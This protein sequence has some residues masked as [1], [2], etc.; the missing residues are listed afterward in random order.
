MTIPLSQILLIEDNDLD[1]RFMQS[2][3]STMC[4]GITV[5]RARDGMAGLE[6]V[7]QTSPDVI[8]LDL[9]MPG[10]NGLEVLSRLKG[11]EEDRH[12]PVI[13]LSTSSND[14]DVRRC[15]D[16]HANA[17]VVKPDSL[18]GYRKVAEDI[19]RFWNQTAQLAS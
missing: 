9:S 11:G 15:Y 8:V 10:L 14:N 12:R 18:A 7:R 19:C 1:A 5:N 4:E 17:Y 2:A 13:I 6:A 3:F 16:A